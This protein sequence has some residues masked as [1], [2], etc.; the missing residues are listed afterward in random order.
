MIAIKS[1]IRRWLVC[2]TCF[3]C[4]FMVSWCFWVARHW[5]FRATAT[6]WPQGW[7][8][9]GE[10]SKRFLECGSVDRWTNRQN[11]FCVDFVKQDPVVSQLQ[12]LCFEVERWHSTLC[13]R[14]AFGWIQRFMTKWMFIFSRF[15]FLC[16]EASEV[17]TSKAHTSTPKVLRNNHKNNHQK[18]RTQNIVKQRSWLHLAFLR[19]QDVS[20]LLT[21]QSNSNLSDTILWP[22]WS[23]NH[24]P[25]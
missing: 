14:S 20:S 24:S 1:A 10:S 9:R 11:T 16:L 18:T 3:E 15:L 23:V 5:A 25:K 22:L 12:L 7:D 21:F 2:F 4:L 13:S 19:M 17:E 8:V 6:T